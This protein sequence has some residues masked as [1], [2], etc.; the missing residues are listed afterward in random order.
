MSSRFLRLVWR[1][2]NVQIRVR[3]LNWWTLGLFVIQPAIFSA[4]GMLLSRLAGHAVPDL[5]YTV[6]GG[7]IMGMWSGLVFTSTFDITRD[8]RDGTLELIVGS[9]TSLGTVEAI[10]TFT[11]VVT[12]LF[13]LGAAFL[14]AILVYRYSLAD[15]NLGGALISLFL[16]L[17]GM[18]CIGV[19]LANFLAWSRL[20]GSLVDFLETPVAVFCGFMYPIRVLPPWMQAVSSA[21]P[22][23]WALQGLDACLH[24][25]YDIDFLWQ[26]WAVALLLSL[27]FWAL[28]LWLQGKVHDR[29][30]VS[31]ELSSI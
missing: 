18:W 7:G 1:Q 25:E 16:I 26:P 23:R 12:G 22:I 8:R 20:T 27:L 2:M 24:G 28:A 21:I 19:F 17:F 13:S 10:R 3:T 29:I 11:N 6:I 5:V 31:G 30:R 15:V 9:P 4:V 14:F